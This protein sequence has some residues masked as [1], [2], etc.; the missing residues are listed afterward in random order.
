MRRGIA[1]LVMLS[2]SLGLTGCAAVAATSGKP[3]SA[4]PWQ[5]SDGST[6]ADEVVTELA[7]KSGERMNPPSSVGFNEEDYVIDRLLKIIDGSPKY[8]A[9]EVNASSGVNRFVFADGSKLTL[10][11]KDTSAASDASEDWVFLSYDVTVR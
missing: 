4:A 9:A 8:K 10:R 6:I 5:K 3:A 11:S 7:P 1:V 2:L